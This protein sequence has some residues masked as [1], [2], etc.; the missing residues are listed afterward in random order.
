MIGSLFPASE[1]SG[2]SSLGVG[3][4]IGNGELEMYVFDRY[5][6]EDCELSNRLAGGKSFAGAGE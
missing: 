4:L 1:I 5:L 6:A 3:T 2:G